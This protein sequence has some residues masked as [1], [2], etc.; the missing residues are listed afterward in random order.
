[1]LRDG[2][3]GLEETAVLPSEGLPGRVGHDVLPSAEGRV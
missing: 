1:L 2:E 3:E